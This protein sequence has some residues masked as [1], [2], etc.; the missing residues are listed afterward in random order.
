MITAKLKGLREVVRDAMGKLN[1]YRVGGG[2]LFDS[3][4][5]SVA[6]QTALHYIRTEGYSI[7]H[8]DFMEIKE[9]VSYEIS[10]VETEKHENGLLDVLKSKG[11]VDDT[12]PNGDIDFSIEPF[13]DNIAM[14]TISYIQINENDNTTEDSFCLIRDSTRAIYEAINE[15]TKDAG[16][17]DWYRG[18]IAEDEKELA[19]LLGCRNN[20]GKYT[21]I[22]YEGVKY[23]LYETW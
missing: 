8:K 17:D 1:N 5:S 12:I 22:K 23:R 21:I 10:K 16:Y 4:V 9:A 7:S 2:T 18:V 11:I 15:L 20:E 14:C 13:T 3:C 19:A 6:Y